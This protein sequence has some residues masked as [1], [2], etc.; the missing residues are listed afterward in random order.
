MSTR[1]LWG[2]PMVAAAGGALGVF[3]ARSVDPFGAAVNSTPGPFSPL[4]GL[5]RYFRGGLR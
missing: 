1:G 3:T 5:A 2:H 4:L